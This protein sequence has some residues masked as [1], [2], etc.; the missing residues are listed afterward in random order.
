MRDLQ[1]TGPVAIPLTTEG[2]NMCKQ[3]LQLLRLKFSVGLEYS[4]RLSF[5]FQY[6]PLQ[7]CL[8]SRERLEWLAFVPG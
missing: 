2:G 6:V 4:M 7:V 5:R 3:D 1:L 8:G